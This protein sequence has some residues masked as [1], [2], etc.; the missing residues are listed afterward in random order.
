MRFVVLV[1]Q[2]CVFV[3]VLALNAAVVAHSNMLVVDVDVEC[4]R[5]RY[6]SQSIVGENGRRRFAAQ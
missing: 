5:R 6:G 1:D 4:G 2:Q 3:G